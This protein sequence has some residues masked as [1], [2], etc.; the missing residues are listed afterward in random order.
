MSDKAKKTEAKDVETKYGVGA[1]L[2]INVI[3]DNKMFRFEMPVG[4][5][6]YDSSKACNICLDIIEKMIKEAEEKAK[7]EKESKS[8]EK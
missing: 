2:M 6:L 7:T 1:S 5:S 4:I 8:E 3:Q